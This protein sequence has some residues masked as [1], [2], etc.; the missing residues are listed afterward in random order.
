[1]CER[2]IFNLFLIE[3]HQLVFKL[4]ASADIV[5]YGYRLGVDPTGDQVL[6]AIIRGWILQPLPH[7]WFP[8][9]PHI[10]VISPC[11][12]EWHSFNLLFGL[13]A[14]CNLFLPAVTTSSHKTGFTSI[15]L[16]D[17]HRGS[18]RWR[19]FTKPLPKSTCAS[20]PLVVQQVFH[21]KMFHL[22][23]GYIIDSLPSC[24]RATYWFWGFRKRQSRRWINWTIHG[25]WID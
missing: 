11:Q 6:C 14:K 15:H 8:W 4:I 1:M 23:F 18:I 5:D 22:H 16:T 7:Y 24:W 20:I 13:F 19:T 17:S 25:K 9:Y 21:I 12:V 2:H 10:F 3:C